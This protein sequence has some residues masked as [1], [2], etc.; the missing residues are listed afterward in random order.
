MY[1]LVNSDRPNDHLFRLLS[2]H[3]VQ[4]QGVDLGSQVASHLKKVTVVIFFWGNLVQ[5][6]PD[7]TGWSPE[8]QDVHQ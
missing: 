7:R 8:L 5:C 2:F 6:S 1:L 3:V 4:T